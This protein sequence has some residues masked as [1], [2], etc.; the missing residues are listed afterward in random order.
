[1]KTQYLRYNPVNGDIYD[2]NNALV[3]TSMLGYD[4]IE[5]DSKPES[6]SIDNMIKLKNAGFTAEEVINITKANLGA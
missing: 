4:P 2:K 6:T 5:I 1:M 3:T